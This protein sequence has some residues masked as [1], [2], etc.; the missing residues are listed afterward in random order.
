MYY[1]SGDALMFIQSIV[2]NSKL[3]NIDSIASTGVTIYSVLCSNVRGVHW[4]LSLY[5]NVLHSVQLF[6]LLLYA[7]SG[8]FCIFVST[9]TFYCPCIIPN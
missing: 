1:I 5:A 2:S 9:L 8:E 7:G 3:G 6:C 4:S